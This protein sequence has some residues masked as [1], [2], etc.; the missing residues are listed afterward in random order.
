MSEQPWLTDPKYGGMSERSA[1][2]SYEAWVRQ[3][4]RTLPLAKVLP[5]P[6]AEIALMKRSVGIQLDEYEA[7]IAAA[8]AWMAAW[9]ARRPKGFRAKRRRGD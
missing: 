5:A 9:R 8:A 4:K 3:G 7:E 2:L 6:D 1:R